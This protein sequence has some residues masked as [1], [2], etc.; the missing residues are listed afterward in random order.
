MEKV[1]Y[2]SDCATARKKAD[3][4]RY[5]LVSFII[6]KTAA[7]RWYTIKCCKVHAVFLAIDASNFNNGY[8]L[9]EQRDINI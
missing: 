9:P 3:G 2:I 8:A 6:A 5:P 1:C 7:A 4:L